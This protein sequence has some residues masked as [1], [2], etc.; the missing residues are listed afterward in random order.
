MIL[1][2]KQIEGKRVTVDKLN[3]YREELNKN[4]IDQ[5]FK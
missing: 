4:K 1:D 5:Y 3:E 2:I